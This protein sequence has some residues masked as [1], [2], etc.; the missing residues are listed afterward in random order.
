MSLNN[1]T[2]RAVLFDAD[3]VLQRTRP[4]F[5]DE[6]GRL[7]GEPGNVEAFIR[8]VFQAEKPCL[9]GDGDFEALLSSVLERWGSPVSTEDALR[10]WTMIDPD[11]HALG[12]IRTLRGNGTTVALATNQQ[13][14][15]ADFM[16]NGLGYA[17]EFDHILCS[18]FLGYAKPSVA[19]F[20]KSVNLLGIPAD[21]LLFIDDH[22]SNVESAK[23]AGLQAHRY[24]LDEGPEALRNLLE[25]YGL[26]VP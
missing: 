15:R 9:V 5:L 7:C 14:H 3:G 13:R 6:L 22:E 10:V 20:T 21:E 1:P 23:V 8:D 19:Y 25:R 11:T 12:L 18:C 17:D 26:V 24:H 2:I 4:G 16:L